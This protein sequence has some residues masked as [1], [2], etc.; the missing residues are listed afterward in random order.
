MVDR[1]KQNN[2]LVVPIDGMTCASCVA[3]VKRALETVPGVAS[4]QV[5][6][7]TGNATLLI[8]ENNVPL[9]KLIQVIEDTG[10]QIPVSRTNI[11]IGGMTCASCVNAV[12][13]SLKKLKSVVSASVNLTL[14]KA[15]VEYIPEKTFF[16]DIRKAVEGSGYTVVHT[17][18]DVKDKHEENEEER[19]SKSKEI[20]FLKNRF[21]F[22]ISIGILLL[23]GSFDAFPWVT[24]FMEQWY[25]PPILWAIATPVQFWAAWAFYT[26]GINAARHYRANMYTLIA[27]GTS[28]AY[29]YS[30]IIVLLNILDPGLLE[31][32]G[33]PP[34]VYFDTASLIIGLILFGRLL[35]TK[36][37]GKTT[38]A[39]RRLIRLKAKTA[40]VIRNGQESDIPVEEV[41]V[42]DIV[43]VRPGDK[44]PVDGKVLEGNSAVDEST[45][46]GESIPVEKCPGSSVY[47]ATINSNGFLKFATTKV[48]KHTMLS[49]I[50]RLVEEVQETKV[51]VQRLA[52][53]VS[54]YFVPAVLGIALVVFITWFAIGPEP[55]I[56]SAILPFVAVLIIACPCALGLTT[57]TAIVVGTGKGAEKGIL[58]RKAEALE[59]A[60]KVTTVVLD[61]TGTLTSGKIRVTDIVALSVSED[62][63]LLLAASAEQH[64]EHPVGQA[65]RNAI[66][67]RNL[68]LETATDFRAIPGYGVTANINA[69]TVILGN[70]KFMDTSNISLSNLETQGIQFSE[71][72]KTPIFVGVDGKPAGIIAVA[73]TLKPKSN[74]VIENLKAM[75]LEVIILTGDNQHVARAIGDQLG[76]DKIIAEVLP[77]D[78][79]KAVQ[80]L[81]KEGRI[82]A[83]VGDGINDAPALVEAD[84][85]LAI[86]TGTDI[87]MESA[88][89]TLI[90]GD[91]QGIW[92]T[93]RLSHAVIKTIKQNLFWAFFYNIALIPVA[94]GV[95]FPFFSMIGGVPSGL[96]FFFGDLGFLNPVLAALAMAF[97]SV[98]VVTN[99]LRLRNTNID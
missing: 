19:L 29:G 11:T 94:A 95:L 16:E 78:K 85:G 26:S 67:Q 55:A 8:H 70:Q 7:A 50:I 43:I 74:E 4:A 69:S 88:S 3:N 59:V 68:S 86:G 32:N 30:S 51:P 23:I 83:M 36:A 15:A 72:G 33:I 21:V 1:T 5:N 47:G 81:Q 6:L 66:T 62:D 37:K 2:K 90:R 31:R 48:G 46:T 98:T 92:S 57:T 75:G 28:V 84:V 56:I 93:I 18:R 65:I 96:Q 99:S 54:A 12:E 64:S 53:T 24:P 80:Q 25:Y 52:D 87:A 82:V 61:K 35:E 10:Y 42:G 27:L 89:I 39:I 38:E 60:H 91:L 13:E 20:R 58:I 40:V 41:I 44:I 9:K 79:A 22:A 34:N 73:D 97:S 14:E 63:L 17:D 49:S 77:Q 71:Q 76:I 45:I